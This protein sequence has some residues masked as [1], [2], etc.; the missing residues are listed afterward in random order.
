MIMKLC[1]LRVL[2]PE[3]AMKLVHHIVCKF[4]KQDLIYGNFRDFNI[5]EV[6][7]H[8]DFRTTTLLVTKDN[9]DTM[10]EILAMQQ[11]ASER[12]KP[13]HFLP[14]GERNLLRIPTLVTE[15]AQHGH[16][17]LLDGLHFVHQSIPAIQRFINQMY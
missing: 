14:L 5:K 12:K 7:R 2:R 8:T 9:I 15:A 10:S 4:A 17:V 3:E 6:Y 1:L 11:G 16:W 13:V